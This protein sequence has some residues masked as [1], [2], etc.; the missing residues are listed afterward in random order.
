MPRATPWLSASAC[1]AHF[2]VSTRTWRR[3]VHADPF[4]RSTANH[5]VTRGGQGRWHEDAL[6]AYDRKLRKAVRS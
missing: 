6:T 4:L 3:W 2:G 5:R 1:A